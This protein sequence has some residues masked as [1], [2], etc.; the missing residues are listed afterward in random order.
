MATIENV[1]LEI[2]EQQGAAAALVTYNLRG[3]LQDVQQQIRYAELVQLIGDDRGFG[4]DGQNEPIPNG[5]ISFAES[6]VFTT[7][8]PVARPP[9]LLALPSSSLDEDPN[10]PLH[11]SEEDEI[12]ALVT[13]TRIVTPVVAQSNLV[14]RGG[15]VPGDSDPTPV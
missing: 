10:G 3:S 15:I 6:V 14:R 9:R 7:T 12:R 11:T 1:R 8:A 4:E 5:Q 2:K 13:L